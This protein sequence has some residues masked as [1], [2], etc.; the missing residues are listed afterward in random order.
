[1]LMSYV[2]VCTTLYD[3]D[4]KVLDFYNWYS[5]R[6]IIGGGRCACRRWPASGV[7]DEMIAEAK[8]DK[9][10]HIAAAAVHCFCRALHA[11]IFF[12]AYYYIF[13]HHS[14][15]SS[16]CSHFS[17]VIVRVPPST[18]SLLLSIICH[19]WV[20]GGQDYRR[21]RHTTSARMVCIYIAIYYIFAGTPDDEGI[22]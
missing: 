21:Y 9:F 19:C 17:C 2:H 6:Q 18:S 5:G 15:S 8:P 1:M 10:I 22:D 13:I 11:F 4:A 16:A 20:V 12:I 3:D 14:S 7:A